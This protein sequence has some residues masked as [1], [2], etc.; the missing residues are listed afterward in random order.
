MVEGILNATATG[1]IALI[2]ALVPPELQVLIPLFFYTFLIGVYALFVWFFYRFMAKRDIIKLGLDDKYNN[3]SHPALAKLMAAILYTVEFLIALPFT[4]FFWF[5][6]FSVIL[7]VLVKEQTI[8]QVLLISASVVMAVRLTAYITE[9]LSKDLAKMIPFTL[10]G[11]AIVTP[12]F[13]RFSETLAKLS[14]IGDLF[15]SILYYAVAII[16]V[17]IILRIFYVPLSTISALFRSSDS[18]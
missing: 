8:S 18:K 7:L 4:V 9:D 10:L 14:S 16:V 6:I 17:E 12:G 3:V 13:F 5:S 11:V 2:D 15:S 1:A